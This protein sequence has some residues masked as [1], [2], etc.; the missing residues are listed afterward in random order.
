[1]TRPSEV[2]LPLDTRRPSGPLGRRL[3]L[4]TLVVG[5]GLLA[6]S[7]LNVVA[8][9]RDAQRRQ[10]DADLM[11]EVGV[12]GASL[13]DYFHRSRDIASI[14]SRNSVFDDFYLA[15]PN[16]I[17]TIRAGG[18]LMDDIHDSLIAIED[19]FQDQIN[20]VC[21]IDLS[22]AENARVV[23]GQIAAMNDLSPDE[24]KEAF[25]DATNLVQPGDVHQGVPYESPDT[26]QWVIS[27][28]TPV[29]LDDGTVRSL[30]HFEVSLESFRDQAIRTAPGHRVY[31]V[32][33]RTGLI[34]L[35][36]HR[37][38]TS[39]DEPGFDDL[40]FEALVKSG[41][42]VGVATVGGERVAFARVVTDLE[43]QNKWM[44]VVGDGERESATGRWTGAQLL[45]LALALVVVLLALFGIW[46]NER[47]LRRVANTDELTGA[48]NRRALGNRLQQMTRVADDEC[49]AVVLIDLDGFKQVNDRLGHQCGDEL[50]IAVTNR[51][52]SCTRHSDV[53]ARIGGDEFAVLLPDVGA[54][55]KAVEVVERIVAAVKAPLYFSGH[56]VIVGASAGIAMTPDHGTDVETLLRAADSAM[57]QIK[58]SGGGWAV[59][60]YPRVSEQPV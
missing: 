19:R 35:D 39:R 33:M 45:T 4:V 8:S 47:S 32:D 54:I 15:G 58:A 60:V 21:F 3:R 6:A 14:I 34:L 44:V 28:S 51:I 31:V 27:N 22:G 53:V 2:R 5:L 20:E 43:N 9:G 10:R 30:L 41:R 42:D 13:S 52:R 16:R 57:Y 17:E 7:V 12:Q 29:A 36:T 26:G 23:R 40:S 49:G 38:S 18:P 59:A 48:F 25:F 55:E 24:S 11:L 46:A 50:L 37:V 1:M 56:E